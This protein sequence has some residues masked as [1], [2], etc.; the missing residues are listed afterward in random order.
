[1]YSRRH[2]QHTHR[3]PAS[4]VAYRSWFRYPFWSQVTFATCPWPLPIFYM[5]IVRC[6]EGRCVGKLRCY[7][8]FLVAN[9]MVYV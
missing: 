8:V 3:Y 2:T 4:L 1:M 9:V 6:F 7:S 5:G